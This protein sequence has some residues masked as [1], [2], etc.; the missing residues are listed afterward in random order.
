MRTP[1]ATS[2]DPT[3]DL[4]SVPEARA[5]FAL[6]RHI[7]PTEHR[8]GVAARDLQRLQRLMA[9]GCFMP[10]Q[11]GTGA[12]WMAI[13][14]TVTDDPDPLHEEAHR[15]ALWAYASSYG[16]LETM[17]AYLAPPV[18]PGTNPEHCTDHEW[19]PL[20]WPNAA[21]SML[22]LHRLATDQIPGVLDQGHRRA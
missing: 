20:L 14:P 1:I 2:I 7:A 19:A 16:H 13:L 4:P 5:M 15:L 9:S 6:W 11:L 17:H 8:V 22:L 3:I 21:R 18:P 12:W 10:P